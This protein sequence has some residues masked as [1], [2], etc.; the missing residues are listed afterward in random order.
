MSFT[1]H[2]AIGVQYAITALAFLLIGFL[3]MLVMRWQLA[4]PTA[5]LPPVM[6]LAVGDTN[7]P[8]GYMVPPARV[9]LP[10]IGIVGEIIANN[11]R[12]PLWG[13]RAMVS[14]VLFIGVMSMIVWA[15]HMFLTGMGTRLGTFFQ[16]TTM[17]IS[18]PSVVL[19]TSLMLSLCTAGLPRRPPS[20]RQWR[21]STPKDLPA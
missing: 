12:R 18:I 16:I 15:Y 20:V 9:I 3:L 13:Y 19:V 11:T 2:K 8:G 4:W 17:I 5:L 21:R 14:S 7:A 10:A 1:D 6:A